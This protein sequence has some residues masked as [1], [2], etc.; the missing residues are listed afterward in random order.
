MCLNNVLEL[1]WLGPRIMAILVM[2]TSQ[3]NCSSITAFYSERNIKIIYYF[4]ANHVPLDSS[5]TNKLDPPETRPEVD[6]LDVQWRKS[7]KCY[8]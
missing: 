8:S 5:N 6:T 4:E 7:C 2:Q 1:I 3:T